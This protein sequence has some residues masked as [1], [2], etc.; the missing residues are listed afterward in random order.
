MQLPPAPPFSLASSSV[1]ERLT[2]GTSQEDS[3]SNSRR[4]TTVRSKFNQVVVGSIPTWSAILS[5]S[6]KVARNAV[7]VLVMVRVHVGQPFYS[8]VA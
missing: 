3:V 7:N 1:V 4:F 8:G 2:V 5:Y 6:V